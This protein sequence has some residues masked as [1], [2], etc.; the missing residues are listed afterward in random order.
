V[1]DRVLSF[2]YKDR[3]RKADV[4][5]ITVDNSNLENFDDPVWRKGAALE[6]SWGY[7]DNMSPVRSCVVTS[8]KGFRVL[9]IEAT[10][11]SVLLN[12]VKKCEVYEDKKISDIVTNIATAAGYGK[13]NQHIDDTKHVLKVVTQARLTDAQFIRRWA[14]KLGFEFYVDWDGFHFHERRLGARPSRVFTYHTDPGKGDIISEPMIDNDITARPGRVRAKGRDPRKKEDI[15][16]AADNDTD[17]DRAVLAPIVATLNPE[18]AEVIQVD[19]GIGSE[20]TIQTAEDNA[21]EATTRAKAKYRR[22]QQVAVKMSFDIVGDPSMFAKTVC[23]MKGMGKRLSIKYWV[24][25]VE[26]D[27]SSAGYRCGLKMVSDGHGG[28]ST[29]SSKAK[30]FSILGVGSGAKGGGKSANIQK[31]LRDF[32]ESTAQSDPAAAKQGEAAL[33]QYTRG[34]NRAVPGIAKT[35]KAISQDST[36]DPAVRAA[37][38]QVVSQLSQKGGE[39]EAKGKPNKKEAKEDREEL[40]ATTDQET[41]RTVYKSGPGRGTK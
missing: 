40:A 3:E 32:T 23:E 9:T 26:H 8:V 37:A 33:S 35:F 30:G 5:S 36:K 12:T 19:P 14:S 34:G 27:L 28:H 24:Q 41:G 39:V 4:A 17:K 1:T 25:E 18:D 38:S 13:T 2:K 6:L 10:A 20:D 11:K 22:A 29:E 15:D 7:P 16:T 31:A 21:T